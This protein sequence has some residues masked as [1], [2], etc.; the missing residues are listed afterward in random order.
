MKT[1]LFTVIYIL[2]WTLALPFVFLNKR[3]RE[4]WPGRLGYGIGQKNHDLWI[5]AAS[6]GEAFLAISLTDHLLASRPDLSVLITTNTSQ[7]FDILNSHFQKY[8]DSPRPEIRICPLD[9]PFI[10]G[11][12]M[13]KTSPRSVVLLE[14]ELWPGILLECA[15]RNRPVLM[16]NGRM[17]PRSFAG[18]LR[19]QNVLKHIGPREV[20]AISPSDASRFATIFE[21]ACVTTMP[22]IKFDRI[23]DSPAISYVANPLSRFFRPSGKLVVLGS[24]RKEEEPAIKETLTRLANDHPATIVALVPRHL[25]RVS[26]WK[27]FLESGT[28]PWI[29]RSNMKE[30]VKPGTIV[31]WDLFGEL[32]AIYAL[33]RTAFVGGSLAPLGGQNFLE[34]LAQG[35]RAVIGPYWNNFHWVGE[36]LMSQGF[37]TIVA[38]PEELVKELGSST[39]MSRENVRAAADEYIASRQ[40]GTAMAALKIIESVSNVAS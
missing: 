40:G 22:N 15:K 26:S 24:I 13:H 17:S 8:T 37:V 33:A 9:H 7:G 36:D 1:K 28:T 2:F 31:L 32:P 3:L 25:H 12:F 18:Y 6:V 21:K 29:L 35:V 30:P 5:Q 39:A 16:V 14:T 4:H 19:F 27:K 23:G 38:T 11:R 34:P 20:M 10:I